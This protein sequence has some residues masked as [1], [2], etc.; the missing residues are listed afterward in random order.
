MKRKENKIQLKL[1][2]VFELIRFEKNL[3]DFSRSSEFKMWFFESE[4]YKAFFIEKMEGIKWTYFEF[5]FF[6]IHI[7]FHDQMLF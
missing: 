2:N 7:N 4:R 3:S 5:I 1:C 6:W